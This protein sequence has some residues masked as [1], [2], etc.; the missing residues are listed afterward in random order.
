MRTANSADENSPTAHLFAPDVDGFHRRCPAIEWHHR[1]SALK[2]F[3]REARCRW[4]ILGV[5]VVVVAVVIVVVLVVFG[6]VVITNK[7]RFLC[8]EVVAVVVGGLLSEN[9]PKHCVRNVRRLTRNERS[10]R[11]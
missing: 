2:K 5:M 6:V 1:Y 4:V 9:G 11:K 3:R 10:K 8:L 7:N